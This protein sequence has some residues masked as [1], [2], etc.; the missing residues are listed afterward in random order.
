MHKNKNTNLALSTGFDRP[1]HYDR[2]GPY[3]IKQYHHMKSGKIYSKLWRV[4][5]EIAEKLQKLKIECF[6]DDQMNAETQ[7]ALSGIYKDEKPV[8]MYYQALEEKNN[9][10]QIPKSS[11]AFGKL[12]QEELDFIK[13]LQK[14]KLNLVKLDHKKKCFSTDCGT[15]YV[16]SST[17]DPRAAITL[18]YTT[19]KKYS[20]AAFTRLTTRQKIQWKVK[21]IEE[22]KQFV[23]ELYVLKR[24]RQSDNSS[25]HEQAVKL[26]KGRHHGS[27]S[28][29]KERQVLKKINQAREELEEMS[30]NSPSE[31]VTRIY[32]WRGDILDTK[33]ALTDYIKGS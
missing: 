25:L 32:T 27:N 3:P 7:S 33:E 22:L 13:K 28:L 11:E 5:M 26:H 10:F 23:N 15:A 24:P 17:T 6:G 8:R 1:A 19:Y 18:L 12:W 20:E 2:S 29:V 4:E 9:Y 16:P 14:L 30:G 31:P 21:E